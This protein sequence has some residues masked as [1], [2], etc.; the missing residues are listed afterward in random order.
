MKKI[1][2]SLIALT[3]SAGLWAETQSVNYID[4]DGQQ[5]TA[6]ATVVTNETG[7]LNAGWYVVTGEVSRGRI[8]CN[9]PVHLI[10]A[11]G[12][13]LTTRG[14]DREAGINVSGAATLT[15]YGQ[16]AQSGQLFAYGGNSGTGIGGGWRSSGS[17]ITINGGK[18]TANGGRYGAGIGGGSDC[19]GS[20]ITIN[21]GTVIATGG[22]S[23]AGIG[24]GDNGSGSNITINGGTITANGGKEGAGIGGGEEGS[25]SNITINGGTVTANGGAND[26]FVASSI[27]GGW[28]GSSSN[29]WVCADCHVFADGNNP[30]TTEI[31]H[32]SDT[33]LASALSARYAFTEFDQ[34]ILSEL[35]AEAIA[36]IDKVIEG[37]TDTDILAI[38]RET[39][40]CITNANGRT[41]I[42][43]IKDA[44]LA[45]LGR[46]VRIY[47][48]GKAEAFGPLG[49]EKA[50]T[51]VKVTKGD[52]EVILYAPDKVEYIIRK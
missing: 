28:K 13:K 33:D 10:L 29:I 16:S 40:N 42:T 44:L 5:K 6:T 1:L 15:I 51:A 36:A 47:K 52:K 46:L 32:G 31:Q 22:I 43:T 19:S 23:G 17:N 27:G 8:Y 7:T 14:G 41:I 48:S 35:R 18:I 3:L 20:N 45:E 2:L 37:V 12:A 9:G 11:D 49:E 21:G 34:T 38:V 50:G 24:G 4:A 26:S 25:G 39:K 30:P